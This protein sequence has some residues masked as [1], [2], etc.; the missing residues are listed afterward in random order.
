[1]HGAWIIRERAGLGN[2]REDPGC[3]EWAVRGAKEVNANELGVRSQLEERDGGEKGTCSATTTPT[4][5][6][7]LEQR[8]H[9][10][11]NGSL[12]SLTAIAR[13]EPR[14]LQ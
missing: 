12:R 13:L 7:Y 1:M 11:H 2:T 9:H 6:S 10:R 14:T 3:G 4:T 5:P 8:P